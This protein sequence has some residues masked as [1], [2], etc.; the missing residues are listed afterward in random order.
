MATRRRIALCFVVWNE[1]EGCEIDLPT[2]DPSGFDEVFAIDGGSTD[3]TTAIF[4]RYHIPVHQQTGRGLNAAYWQAVETTSC[5]CVV[6]FFPKGTLST[7]ILT[8][9]KH[10]LLNGQE[11]VVASRL[12]AGGRNEED[13]RPFRPRKWG[14]RALALFSWLA[15]QRRGP[16]VWDV[17][18]GVKGFSRQAFLAMNPSRSG[19]TID[20]EMV[21]RSYKLGIRPLEFPVREHARGFGVTRFKILPTGVKLTRCLL[22]EL[23]TPLVREPRPVQ[24][25]AEV[26]APSSSALLDQ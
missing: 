11:F 4:E 6:V 25:P 17:L 21:I 19:L 26:V 20:L 1:R 13:A 9:F 5:D 18:H 14:V 7:S 22:A 12:I 16:V 3:G 24:R 2:V 23:R 8:E 15:W 10:Y